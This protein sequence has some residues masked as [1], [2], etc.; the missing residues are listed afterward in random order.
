VIVGQTVTL[1]V[2]TP[3]GAVNWSVASTAIATIGAATGVVTGVA[4]GQTT[5]T[6]TSGVRSGTASVCVTGPLSVTPPS[7]AITAGRTAQLT[8]SNTSGGTVTYVSS[9]TNIATV[10]ATGLVRGVGVGQS[11]ITTRLTAASGTQTVTTPV[12]VSAAGIVIVP[13]TGTAALTRTA[14]FTA[15]VQDATGATIPG[16]SVN[17][18]I[19]DA[20]VGGLSATSATAVDVLALK[21]GTTTVRATLGSSSATAQFT[22]TQPLPPVRLAKVSGDGA[23]CLTRSTGCTFVVRALDVNG[24]AVP[25]ASVSWSGSGACGS[26]TVIVTDDDGLSTATN[27]CSAVPAGTYSQTATLLA[28]QQQALFS[29]TLRGLVLASQGSDSFGAVYFGVTTP[30]VAAS[31]LKATVEYKSGPAT[32]YVTGL[33]L[34][35]TTTPAT[36]R[37]VYNEIQI[38]FGTYTFDVIVSTTTSG[39]GPGM[40]T[41]TFNPDSSFGFVARPGNRQLPR[42][43]QGVLKPRQ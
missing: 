37:V 22:A 43:L 20:T 13:S 26:P 30:T 28:N 5:V 3:P 19:T 7:I 40:A 11:T 2:V 8:A 1:N 27:I 17:W 41:I 33:D 24:A 14:R 23:I 15:N 16:V 6:A 29:Y 39:I 18:S 10:D 34:D 21:V 9:A 35:R 38:P 12:T 32:N 31:G 25:G 4:L 36:L 42:A